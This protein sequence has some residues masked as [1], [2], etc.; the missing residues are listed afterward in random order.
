MF[1]HKIVDNCGNAEKTAITIACAGH[2]LITGD[3][4]GPQVLEQVGQRYGSHVEIKNIGVSG[5]ALL[6]HL[7]GQDLLLVV[8]AALMG[9]PT[10][11]IRVQE[12]QNQPQIGHGVAS[13]HQIGPLETLAVAQRL[14]PDT[15][16]K[17]VLLILV[18][19]AGLDDAD[20]AA[21]SHQVVKVLDQQ[22]ERWVALQ[23]FGDLAPR[24]VEI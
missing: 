24:P 15:M 9:T 17:Q 12:Y 19:T 10:G 7:C 18:E 11:T 22:V 13:T 5:L 21:V 3:R 8:D 14:F 1:A 4:I 23:H 16:P 20:I 6:D 2:W